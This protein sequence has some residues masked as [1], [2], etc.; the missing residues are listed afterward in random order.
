[1]ILAA[2][3]FAAWR[4]MSLVDGDNV[5][6]HAAS[7][8]FPRYDEI[9]STLVAHLDMVRSELPVEESERHELRWHFLVGG[10]YIPF[11][12]PFPTSYCAQFQHTVIAGRSHRDELQT[13]VVFQP[14]S[15]AQPQ[16][17]TLHSSLSQIG[18]SNQF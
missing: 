10:W 16:I 15:T 3:A 17:G 12:A 1:V 14:K 6:R 4:L 11:P 18:G 9:K 13:V 2:A 7:A 5:A 8:G